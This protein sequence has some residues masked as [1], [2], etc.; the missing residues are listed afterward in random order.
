MGGGESPSFHGGWRFGSPDDDDGGVCAQERG[1]GW[2]GFAAV[3]DHDNDDSEGFTGPCGPECDSDEEEAFWF[4]TGS[5]L[6]WLLRGM[7]HMG[8]TG[9][10]PPM[11]DLS[12]EMILAARLRMW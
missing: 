8:P 7:G 3:H 4:E 1:F 10:I 2:F 6:S 11:R 12:V 5:A 9:P